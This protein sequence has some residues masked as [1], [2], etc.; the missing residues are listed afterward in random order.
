[1]SHFVI[2]IL[3]STP[4]GQKISV[5]NL[6]TLFPIRKANLQTTKQESLESLNNG[7][8]IVFFIIVS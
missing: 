8:K 7:Q 3:K 4:I 5:L 6:Q 1:M 2:Y